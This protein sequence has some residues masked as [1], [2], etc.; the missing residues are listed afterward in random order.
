MLAVIHKSSLPYHSLTNMSDTSS[1]GVK[2]YVTVL[3]ICIRNRLLFHDE[4]KT[5]KV[6]KLMAN[7]TPQKENLESR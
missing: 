3:A 7:V 6:P 4:S 5:F 1:N 2:Y